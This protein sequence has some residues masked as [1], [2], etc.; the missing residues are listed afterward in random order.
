MADCAYQ[1]MLHHNE[2]QN[3]VFR[4]ETLSGKTTNCNHLIDHLLY[5]G[6]VI[7]TGLYT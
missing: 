5:L 1:D 3:I 4:G 2:A 6:K 7:Q